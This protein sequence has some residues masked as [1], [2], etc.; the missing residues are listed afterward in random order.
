M[1]LALRAIVLSSLALAIGGCNVV[2]PHSAAKSPLTPISVSPD[3]IT[4]EVFSAPIPQG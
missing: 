4:L 2:E 1:H 3:A